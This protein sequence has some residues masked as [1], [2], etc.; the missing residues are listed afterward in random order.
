[1]QTKLLPDVLSSVGMH[2]KDAYVA[3]EIQEHATFTELTGTILSI[4]SLF[5]VE[6]LYSSL[7]SADVLHQYNPG[8]QRAGLHF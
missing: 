4:T 1:M 6:N 8:V 2:R 3:I 7:L 5:Q